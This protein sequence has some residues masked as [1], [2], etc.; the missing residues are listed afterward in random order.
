MEESH[1][2]HVSHL[3]KYL[4]DYLVDQNYNH[5]T[6]I[7]QAVWRYVMRQNVAYLPS[8]CH[9][10]YLEGL[11]KTGIST[12]LIPSMYGMSRILKDI[13]WYAVAV[14]G[15]IP[16]TV[17]M[18][19]QAHNVLV[20]AAD[21]RKVDHIGYTPAPDILHE[22]AG[23]A[24]IIADKMY[25]NYLQ[26]FGEIGAK[27]FSSSED[28]ELF[29]AIRELSI[30]KEASNIKKDR[31]KTVEK[32]VLNL[33]SSITSFSEMAK[34]RNLHWW[35]VEYGLIGS[36]DAPKIYGAGLLS[37]ISESVT[38]LSEKVKKIRY[39]MNA[40][41][42]GFDITRE[43]PQL[44][45]TED[46]QHLNSVLDD[47]SETMAFKRGGEYGVQ[48]AIN[49]KSIATCELDSGIQISGIF[50]EFIK[51]NNRLIYL[52]TNGPTALAYENKEV[53]SH[54]I[55]HH[56]EGFGTPLGNMINISSLNFFKDKIGESIHIN[57]DTGVIIQGR[58]FNFKEDVNGKILVLSFD[59]CLVSFKD[60]N[61]KD[62]ILFDPSWGVFDLVIGKKISSVYPDAAD[63][64]S[65]P[66]KTVSFKS[67]TIQREYSEQEKKLDLLYSRVRNI[68][69]SN[70]NLD[71]LDDIFHIIKHDF[72]N[73]WLLPLEICELVDV[74]SDLYNQAHKYLL[75]F[76]KR[77][78]DKKKL[79][80]DG[81]KL[82]I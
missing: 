8:V 14:D 66:S 22:A 55:K 59:D 24:P 4:L 25:S 9:G 28:I 13:G 27:A 35:T 40:C 36:L 38:C 49:S 77:E 62:T 29:E 58:L 51:H 78:S 16:P 32:K 82:I 11:K 54:G 52:K 64:N 34:I 72:P 17:F 37:S 1:N 67:Y 33:Q 15:F 23:H 6:S 53:E 61:K 19:F 56:H 63:R 42:V 69:S 80:L 48:Q 79:I 20:I 47:F 12:D 76:I 73:D 74:D 18:E 3:P 2:Q 5:Y 75:S 46:F 7:D 26:K 45:V 39:D 41:N 70:N 60:E 21:I 43:Q 65:F 71:E 30:L 44:F 50:Q 31:I 68:R 57:Y 10:S 81:L